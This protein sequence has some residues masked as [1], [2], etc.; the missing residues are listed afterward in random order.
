MTSEVVFAVNKPVATAY[1]D[2]GGPPF[3]E[4]VK[5]INIGWYGSLTLEPRKLVGPNAW[6][7]ASRVFGMPEPSM[8]VQ[9]QTA[10]LCY[11][12]AELTGV[13]FIKIPKT[14]AYASIT[15]NHLTP[16][17]QRA[18]AVELVRAAVTFASLKGAATRSHRHSSFS[19]AVERFA[20]NEKGSRTFWFSFDDM[21]PHMLRQFLKQWMRDNDWPKAEV[22]EKVHYEINRQGTFL[23]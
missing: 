20:A 6:R 16:G 14:R 3:D 21:S 1:N 8:Y 4:L 11:I 18:K 10:W 17:D 5:L 22:P 2:G 12:T 15:T 9:G 19:H 23:R 7:A 13:P